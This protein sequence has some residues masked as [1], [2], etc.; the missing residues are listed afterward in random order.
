M[1]TNQSKTS[2]NIDKN[3][4]LSKLSSI[5]DEDKID[6]CDLLK[7]VFELIGDEKMY[8]SIFVPPILNKLAILLVDPSNDV[9]LHALYVIRRLSGHT[10]HNNDNSNNNNSNSDDDY[11]NFCDLCIKHGILTIIQTLVPQVLLQI[12]QSINEDSIAFVDSVIG[13]FVNIH[14][15]SGNGTNIMETFDV[16]TVHIVC[17]SIMTSGLSRPIFNLLLCL[18]AIISESKLELCQILISSD[19]FKHISNVAC[20]QVAEGNDDTSLDISS[21]VTCMEITLN[22]ILNFSSFKENNNIPSLETLV[23][24]INSVFV[25]SSY[26]VTTPPQ[27]LSSQVIS[28]YMHLC[29]LLKKLADYRDIERDQYTATMTEMDTE[30]DGEGQEEFDELYK[31]RKNLSETFWN[32]FPVKD[33]QQVHSALSSHLYLLVQ[34]TVQTKILVASQDLIDFLQAFNKNTSCLVTLLHWKQ[35]DANIGAGSLSITEAFLRMCLHNASLLTDLITSLQ[36]HNQTR[37]EQQQ[38]NQD[39]STIKIAY[40][41]ENAP[42]ASI[43]LH[44]L[45]KAL[46][47]TLQILSVILLW[48][49]EEQIAM[50]EEYRNLILNSDIA[51]LLRAISIPN[52]NVFEL[53][54]QIISALAHENM[55]APSNFVL[56][57][58]LQRRL[59]SVSAMDTEQNL[60]IV[61]AG[62]ECIID[63][64]SSDDQEFLNSY[65]KLKTND[66]L[67]QVYDKFNHC[68]SARSVRSLDKEILEQFQETLMN[69]ANFI[70]YKASFLK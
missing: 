66:F 2:T 28:T 12:T 16:N 49:R 1:Q 64:H 65:S 67:A 19:A 34:H 25:G 60:H 9:R 10:S 42:D 53:S 54:T 3:H 5:K 4:L 6:G 55:P 11:K 20:G 70:Q 32:V 7:N 58:A 14:M 57:L 56:T 36:G 8:K 33:V 21:V 27:P 31:K 63:L 15:F 26:Q 48:G 43:T 17:Q 68:L 59:E 29:S 37:E 50:M 30:V 69:T 35:G 22:A 44:N 39:I 51:W 38:Q 23:R 52:D 46:S 18:I 24:R 47:K 45:I 13:S 61:N 40:A 41:E 62:L